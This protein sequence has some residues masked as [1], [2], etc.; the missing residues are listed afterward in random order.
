M[1][2]SLTLVHMHGGTLIEMAV[3]FVLDRLNVPK[4]SHAGYGKVMIKSWKIYCYIRCF[5]C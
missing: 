3:G 1:L 2:Y 5:I 4:L